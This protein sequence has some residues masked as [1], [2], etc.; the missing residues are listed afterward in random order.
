M[1]KTVL[2]NGRQKTTTWNPRPLQ[3][4]QLSL[5]AFSRSRTCWISLKTLSALIM[6]ESILTK[7][8][9]VIIS[10]LRFVRLKGEWLPHAPASKL[11]YATPSAGSNAARNACFRITCQDLDFCILLSRHCINKSNRR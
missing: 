5:K 7:Y 1:A 11:S 3:I 10:I 6:M 8:L 9:Q 4:L 2:W